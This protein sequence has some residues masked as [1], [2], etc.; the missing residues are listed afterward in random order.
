MPTSSSALFAIAFPRL[1]HFSYLNTMR[2]QLEDCRTC[3]DVGCGGDSPVR[4]LRFEYAV[5]VDGYEPLLDRARANRT[6]DR[7][8]LCNATE[9]D[10]YFSPKQFDCC[11]ALDLIEH[12]SKDDGRKLISTMEQIASKKILLFTPNGFLPQQRHE[13]DLQEHLSGWTAEEMRALGFTVIGMHGWKALRGEQHRHRLKPAWLSGIL[14]TLSHYVYTRRHPS[15]AA[16]L[17]CVKS[18]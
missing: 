13:G 18:V 4:H 14:S 2:N 15:Q 7:Y 11:I 8:V 16:A 1:L 6:H 12:L 9:L 17:L 3:L 5:G 10:R